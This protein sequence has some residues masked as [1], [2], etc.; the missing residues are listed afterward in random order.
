MGPASSLPRVAVSIG[1]GRGG[2]A[3]GP[4]TLPRAGTCAS[5]GSGGH[6]G[7]ASS[8]SANPNAPT[9]RSNL[10]PRW[11]KG[12]KEPRKVPPDSAQR[13]KK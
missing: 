1:T 13:R 2:H 12:T 9:H 11:L 3:A 8:S 6:R 4:T 5:P 10:S 7:W